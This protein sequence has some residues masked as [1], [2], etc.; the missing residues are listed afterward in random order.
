MEKGFGYVVSIVLLL[1]FGVL[2]QLGIQFHYSALYFICGFGIVSFVLAIMIKHDVATKIFF[3]FSLI[4]LVSAFLNF[5]YN[6]F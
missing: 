3:L 6:Y 5:G 1:C 2:L 4:L